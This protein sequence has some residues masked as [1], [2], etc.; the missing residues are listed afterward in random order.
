MLCPCPHHRNPAL[1]LQLLRTGSSFS[2]GPLVPR[3]AKQH[4]VASS[5]SRAP[6]QSS[7][8]E[9][10]SMWVGAKPAAG[11]PA[12]ATSLCLA[13]GPELC[14][15]VSL[16]WDISC[17]A[18]FGEGMPR[19]TL[20]PRIPLQ[21]SQ[22]MGA[23]G[24]DAADSPP[25]PQPRGRGFVPTRTSGPFRLTALW[26]CPGPVSAPFVGSSWGSHLLTEH[27]PAAPCPVGRGLRSGAKQSSPASAEP[28]SHIALYPGMLLQREMQG[29]APARHSQSGLSILMW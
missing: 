26:G 16:P 25:P 3:Q 28:A 1:L 23:A 13:L 27:C 17:P 11:L 29:A 5:S 2:F 9:R 12:A 18:A 8:G 6:S 21:H 10:L 22:P 7:F 4:R 20:V 19:A 24:G 15:S 14:S